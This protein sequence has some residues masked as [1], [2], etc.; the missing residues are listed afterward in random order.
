MVLELIAELSTAHRS[1]AKPADGSN[2]KLGRYLSDEL[3]DT[4]RQVGK[5][6]RSAGRDPA[7]TMSARNNNNPAGA[8]GLAER[9]WDRWR[10]GAPGCVACSKRTGLPCKC[11]PMKGSLRCYLHGGRSKGRGKRQLP[12][13][14]RALINQ[15]T[16]SARAQARAAIADVVLLQETRR[17]WARDFAARV[18]PADAERFMLELDRYVRGELDAR[19]WAAIRAHFGV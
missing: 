5:R 8:G 10:F 13:S 2:F 17:V 1:R 4:R 14:M 9:P 7:T 15:D 16:R 19:V 11:P 3:L 6:E 12:T 18:R